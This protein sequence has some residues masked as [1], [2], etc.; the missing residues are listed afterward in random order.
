[1]LPHQGE[2][3]RAAR[4]GASL[5]IRASMVW[6]KRAGMAP[7]YNGA[8]QSPIKD[9]SPLLECVPNLSE[10]RDLAAID[11]LWRQLGAIHGLRC[12]HRTSDPDHHR[13][14][15]TLAGSPESLRAAAHTLFEWALGQIDLRQH[16]GVHPRIGAIDVLPI[17][18]LRGIDWGEAIS[19]SRD[20]GAELASRWQLPIYLYE[21]S[22]SQA[23]R[24][25]LPDI[26]RGGFE[27]L[28]EKMTKPDWAPDFGPDQPHLSLG[29]TV[30][31]VR[32]LL[33]AWNVF[34]NS[35]DLQL[36]QRIAR[37]IR[38]R[39]GGFAA[40]R[41]LGFYLAHRQQVQIS[42]N[43]LDFEQSSLFEIMTR[44]R[45]LA[46]EAGVEVV[47]SEFIGL[48][49]RRALLEAG[50]Q[51]LTPGSAQLLPSLLEEQISPFDTL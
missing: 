16:Q 4:P 23:Q 36:A 15:L 48:L 10:G 1:M 33:I 49:P 42:M 45:E 39:N 43:L 26:R 7:L 20:P 34:L 47:G 5:A 25:A 37:R 28:G 22:A 18:P 30:L 21:Y 50:W 14:V 38:T 29:A 35:D 11:R 2:A 3:C 40:L 6:S 44:I 12:L 46:A 24:V 17:V 41:A 27:G 13:T 32:K 51:Y 8:M 9:A 31:G 19:F